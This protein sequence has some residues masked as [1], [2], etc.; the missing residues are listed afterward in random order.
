MNKHLLVVGMILAL[1]FSGRPAWADDSPLWQKMLDSAQQ[2]FDSGKYSKAARNWSKVVDMLKQAAENTKD[3]IMLAGSLKHLG[4]CHRLRERWQE[5]QACYQDSLNTY[6]K[7]A[8]DTPEV[9]AG[10]ADVS[11]CYKTIGVDSLGE[12]AAKLL[13]RAGAVCLS[14]FKKPDGDHFE[15]ALADIYTQ[16]VNED[17]IEQ[18]R[19]NKRICFD[20]VQTPEGKLSVSKI[21]G[22]DVKADVC[23][24]EP[25][26]TMMYL[27]DKGE[28]TAEV[29]VDALGFMKTVTVNP[30]R[31]IYDYILEMVKQVNSPVVA[32]GSA[33]PVTA[34]ADVLKTESSVKAEDSPVQVTGEP[35]GDS[36]GRS[37]DS[38]AKAPSLEMTN[39]S[40]DGAPVEMTTGT[41]G[42][43][44]EVTK[45]VDVTVGKETESVS[46]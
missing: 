32:S 31:Q 14:S 15:L 30:P 26:S 12:Q 39:E 34:P 9:T 29:T 25:R 45:E 46:K 38:G 20:F 24:V 2:A 36:G 37:L 1:S 7:L 13:K 27:D 43:P 22:V 5:A 44:I 8:P 35:G 6:G 19:F 42:D 17:R 41:G 28:T 3:Q 11:S 40:G 21:K 23:W 4:D 18:V 10:L 16:V 33:A